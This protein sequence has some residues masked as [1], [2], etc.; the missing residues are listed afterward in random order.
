MK[1]RTDF[2]IHWLWAVSF[3]ILALSGFALAGAKYGWLLDYQLAWADYAHRGAAALFTVTT[4]VAIGYYI[5]GFLSKGMSFKSPWLPV[6]PSGYQLFTLVTTLLLIVSG[7]LIWNCNQS[8]KAGIALSLY[9]HDVV[10]VLAT[11]SVI[12]H[13]YKKTHVLLPLNPPRAV[14]KAGGK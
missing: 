3:A 9:I 1:L 2:I 13:V 6:G 7:L 12:W 8:S 10:A 11:L 4:V 5:K 14:K